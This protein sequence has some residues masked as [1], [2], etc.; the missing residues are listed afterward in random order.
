MHSAIWMFNKLA[1]CRTI[2]E[3][4]L[5]KRDN[6]PQL[7]ESDKRYLESI[8]D[9]E[10]YPAAWC[11]MDDEVCMYQRSTSSTSE[12]MNAANMSMRKRSALSM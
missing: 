1:S 12:S 3:P 2:E 4:G 6:Y 8:P 7:K 11:A 10:Q 9:E 5:T